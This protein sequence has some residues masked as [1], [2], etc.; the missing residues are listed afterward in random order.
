MTSPTESNHSS[1]FH[2]MEPLYMYPSPTNPYPRLPTYDEQADWMRLEAER[3]QID[4]TIALQFEKLKE[5]TFDL[6]IRSRTLLREYKIEA[7][8]RDFENYFRLLLDDMI[9]TIN[10]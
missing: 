4:L 10:D 3:H 1:F 9:L 6:G 5:P 7:T 8:H 2:Y